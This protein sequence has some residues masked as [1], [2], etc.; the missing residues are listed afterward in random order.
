[1]SRIWMRRVAQIRTCVYVCHVYTHMH[2]YAC[3]MSHIRISRFVLT[4]SRTPQKTG[5]MR[6][7]NASCHAVGCVVLH[8]LTR[9]CT[10]TIYTHICVHMHASCHTYM[11]TY[12]CVMSH[13][14]MSCVDLR[15]G[16]SENRERVSDMTHMNKFKSKTLSTRILIQTSISYTYE[17]GRVSLTWH[18]VLQCVAV[19]CSVLQCVAVCCRIW[20]SVSDMTGECLW[21]DTFGQREYGRVSLTWH[22]HMN[23]GECLWHDTHAQVKSKTHIWIWES[24]SDIRDTLPYSYMGTSHVR[25][26]LPHMHKSCQRHSPRESVSD[27]F[28]WIWESVS[29]MPY[30][31]IWI[32]ESVSDMT[33]CVAVC[34]SVLQCVAV[35]CRIWESVSDMTLPYEY[36][37]VSLT[38][39]TC[40]S[41][42]KDK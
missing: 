35:C 23:M 1:M 6:V 34:C 38:W 17:Y 7:T 15:A 37:R 39:H 3:V 29:D 14:W 5:R 19:C 42:V 40:T 22:S 21:H 13:V 41:Q 32:W 2:T 24:V 36:G 4:C 9:A 18:S 11:C 12:V 33:Q 27:I 20:E 31:P 10:Y 30:E 8:Y 16:A 26:T 28:I 25:D